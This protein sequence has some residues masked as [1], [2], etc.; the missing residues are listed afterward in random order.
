MNA[1]VEVVE[2]LGSELHVH[3]R[4][5]E[6]PLVSRM[7]PRSADLKP[8]QEIQ[9]AVTHQRLHLFDPETGEAI[10]LADSARR[11]LTANTAS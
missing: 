10:G 5:G 4:A 11:S 9:L 7:D 8:G 3:V 2:T 6:Q 1:R